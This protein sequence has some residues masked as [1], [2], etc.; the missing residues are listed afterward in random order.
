MSIQL[1]VSAS[2]HVLMD[3]AAAR[4]GKSLSEFILEAARA[5]AEEA[6]L[7]RTHF[8]LG[9]D[10]FDAFTALLDEPP[11]PKERLN[12]L[13]ATPRPFMSASERT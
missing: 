10:Q 12:A 13:L 1:R 5:A 6:L 9:P 4:L 11:M 7:D 2:D 8:R 3:G